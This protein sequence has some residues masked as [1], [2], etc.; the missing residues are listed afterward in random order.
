LI[1]VAGFF[2]VL[3]VGIAAFVATNI[4]DLFILMVFFANRSFPTSQIILGQ[5]VGMGLLLG[6]SLIG[7]LIALVVPSNLIGL[8]GIFPIVIGIKEILELRKKGDDDDEEPVKQ[9]SAQSRWRAY[10]P[11]LIVAAVTL[12]GGEEIGIYVSVFAIYNEVSEIITIVTVVIVLTGVWCGI[13]S[14]LVN[15]S[16]LADRLRRIASRV[17]PFLLIG[18]GI[19]ILIEA[20]LIPS[21][22]VVLI[23]KLSSPLDS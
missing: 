15:H 8:I 22:H 3:G 6:V 18:L 20:F 14:Y 10:L 9:L 7:S 19:Y 17:L 12:S 21:L 13:A 2:D 16:F 5:Y 1:L 23:H 4:D 11:F